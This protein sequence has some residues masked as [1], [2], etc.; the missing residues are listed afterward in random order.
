MR[1]GE[2]SSPEERTKRGLGGTFQTP[3]QGLGL[4]G[5]AYK[6]NTEKD[7]VFIFAVVL[8]MSIGNWSEYFAIAIEHNCNVRSQ[9]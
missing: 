9:K 1:D 8:L 5:T 6:N 2:V 4:R 3:S 7:Y